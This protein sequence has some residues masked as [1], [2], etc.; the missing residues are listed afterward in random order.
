MDGGPPSNGERRSVVDLDG[1]GAVLRGFEVV[2]PRRG[3]D[4]LHCSPILD[5]APSMDGG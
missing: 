4:K 2:D 3:T 5:G 1:A